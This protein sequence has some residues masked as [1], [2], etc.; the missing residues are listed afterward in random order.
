MR[1]LVFWSTGKDSALALHALRTLGFKVVGL[2]TTV[3]SSSNLIT[4]HRVPVELAR[5]QAEKLGLPLY[6]VELPEDFPPIEVYED[7]IVRELQRIKRES[8]ASVV[9][10]GDIYIR[11]MIDY[12][13]KLLEKVGMESLYPLEGLSS[14]NVVEAALTLDVKALIVAA[15]PAKL[16]PILAHRLICSTL[17]MRMLKELPAAADI[18]GER[19]EYH[20]FVTYMPGFRGPINV[21][22]GGVRLEKW[23]LGWKLVCNVELA[24]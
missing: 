21:R 19:G 12:K 5:V 17:D 8:G 11:D 18:A 4:G 10:H 22:V 7:V 6:E 13:R 2:I 3:D 23:R 14:L 16:G 24:L 15:D 20:T 9:A 1:V